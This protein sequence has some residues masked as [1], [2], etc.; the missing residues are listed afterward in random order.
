MVKR[1]TNSMKKQTRGT[2]FET[3]AYRDGSKDKLDYEGFLSP[4]VLEG[5][6]YYLHK[7]RLQ[8]NGEYRDSDNWQLGIDIKTY[9][10]SLIRHTFQAWGT[11]RGHKV[12]DDKGDLVTLMDSLY[13]IMFN[14]QG[15]IFELLK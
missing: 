11:W 6:A 1:K 14:V 12:Y 2:Y 8:S 13:G 9:R 4:L 3:G 15:Y 5:Y 7:H 10:K